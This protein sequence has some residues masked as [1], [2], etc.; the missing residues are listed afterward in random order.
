MNE[1]NEKTY[2]IIDSEGN[3]V[4]K[5]DFKDAITEEGKEL[6]VGSAE[7]QLT[8]GDVK[9]LHKLYTTC[10]HPVVLACKH[11]LDLHVQPRHRNCEHCWF[12][13]FNQHGELVQQL[14]EMHTE[15]NDSVIVAL[16]GVKF[17]HRWRQFMSTI[18]KW[19]EE[20]EETTDATRIS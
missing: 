19:K 13:F 9:K 20:N 5:A 3:L 14:D 17:L 11:R 16:Q 18:A 2:D 1:P 7:K 12:A 15:G 4:E 8:E 6:V 10:R